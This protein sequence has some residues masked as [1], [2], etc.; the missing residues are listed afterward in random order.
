MSGLICTCV[1]CGDK[2][3]MDGLKSEKDVPPGWTQTPIG[4]VCMRHDVEVSE[5]AD[6]EVEADVT[7]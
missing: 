5:M 3:L 4:P 2:Y 1:T 7:T 6:G